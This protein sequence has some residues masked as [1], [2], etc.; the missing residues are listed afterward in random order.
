MKTTLDKA[1]RDELIT[2]IQNLNENSQAQWGKMNVSQMIRHC[3]EWED[4]ASGKMKCKQ[5]FVGRLF[6]KMALRSVLKDETPLKRNTPTAPELKTTGNGDVSAEKEKWISKLKEQGQFS[7]DGIVHPF[8]GKMTLEQVG[9]MDYKHI[10]HH[11]R[12]FG[13]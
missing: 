8:F 7:H 2:R 13:C 11:L 10:D 1:T 12:Q 5:V 3:T 6:G 4:L 9:V